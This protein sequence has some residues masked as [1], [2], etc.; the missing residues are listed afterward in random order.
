MKTRYWARVW[1]KEKEMPGMREREM[2][3]KASKSEG[4]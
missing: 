1:L 2:R 4:E 3:G